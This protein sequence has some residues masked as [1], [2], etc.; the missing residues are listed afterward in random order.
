MRLARNT[1]VVLAAGL[2]VALLVGIMLGA[3]SAR[4]ARTASASGV[5]YLTIPAAAFAPAFS[6]T[7]YRN[8][9]WRL[10]SRGDPPG[11]QW[12]QAPINLPQ[13]VT[14]H[15]VTFWGYDGHSEDSVLMMVRRFPH[16]PH[17]KDGTYDWMTVNLSGDS[18]DG[19]Y[20]EG[21]TGPGFNQ[22]DN[23]NYGYFVTVEMPNSPEDPG[24]MAPRYQLFQVRIGYSYSTYLPQ[25]QK[26]SMGLSSWP[27]P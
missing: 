3:V 21:T 19:G 23:E 4:G 9:G 27:V 24:A 11:T 10:Y 12:F 7:G 20:F 16:S 1:K 26:E 14:I 18:F 6:S 15:R 8:D 17:A 13:G 25:V 5:A 22:V 2:L